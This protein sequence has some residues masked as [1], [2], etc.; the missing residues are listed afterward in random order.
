[1]ST[2][3]IL[4]E[5]KK[6]FETGV[7]KSIK[8]R[9]QQLSLLKKTIEAN[10]DKIFEALRQDLGKNE[11]ESYMC[12]VALVLNEIKYGLKHLKKWA[13]PHAVGSGIAN[14]PSKAVSVACP[15]GCVL[16]M[17]PWNY[18][19]MLTLEPLV[20]A[21][22]AGNTAI[23]KP[24]A[25]SPATSEL[26]S[27]LL[28][29]TFKRE[30]VAV[31]TGG[32]EVNQDLLGLDFD[33]IFFTGSK[34]VGHEVLRR[35][36]ANMVPVTLELGGKSPCI[37]DKTAP[38]PLAA[39]RIVFGKLLNVGQTC[40]APDYILVHE[41]VKDMLVRSLVYE[42]KLQYGEDTLQNYEYG[43]MISEKHFD[44]AVA[45]LSEQKIIYGGKYDKSSL[46]IEP[47][48]V[49][50]PKLDSPI[51]QNEI[52]APILPIISYKTEDEALE[53]IRKNDTPLA[54]YVFANDKKVQKYFTENVMFGGGCINDTIMHITTP[55]M[56]FGGVGQ[57]GM[58]AYHGKRGFDTF[59]HYKTILKKS[60]KI[61][62][63]L[64]YRPIGKKKAAIIKKF[65]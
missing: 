52:F 61:D 18:P 55:Q 54:L 19:F 38:V 8:F 42:I 34:A 57:S 47:T 41:S 6:Y 40:I 51:M 33:H 3:E 62:L 36:E 43:K 46:K 20:D 32:R 37:V 56:S 27:N 15:K 11:I 65:I 64:R 14:F 2:L 35:A 49:D 25:Y 44:K 16:I 13:K 58:G 29:S 22:L 23:V 53:I 1:M 7:T 63:P 39:K 12:E 30:Y 21:L 5:Q 48:L 10:E 31:V 60:T 45:L 59:S 24:S 28:S 26:I 9:K 50:E 4:Q 17:S